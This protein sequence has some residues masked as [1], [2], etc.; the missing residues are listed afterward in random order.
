MPRV[1]V[2]LRPNW[3]RLAAQRVLP[4]RWRP[5]YVAVAASPAVRAGWWFSRLVPYRL[6]RVHR[7]YAETFGFFWLPCPLCGREFGGHENRPSRRPSSVP[8]ENRSG[9]MSMLICPQCV[10]AGQGVRIL[11]VRGDA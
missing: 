7:A 3:L 8:D 5:A 10:R 4:P 1:T 2:R 11:G 9:L 6:R